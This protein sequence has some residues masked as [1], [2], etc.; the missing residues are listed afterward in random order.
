MLLRELGIKGG[1]GEGGRSRA[2]RGRELC[3]LRR[4]VRGFGCM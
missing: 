2:E 1:G 3:A 4:C